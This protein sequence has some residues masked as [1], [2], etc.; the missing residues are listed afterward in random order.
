MRHAALS[1]LL[2]SVYDDDDDDDD[3]YS[4]RPVIGQTL[5]YSPVLLPGFIV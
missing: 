1:T 3:A 2:P 4:Q 5:L